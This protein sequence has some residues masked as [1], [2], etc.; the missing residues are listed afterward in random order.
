MNSPLKNTFV[1]WHALF[2]R[3][4]LDRFF[5]NRAGWVWYIVEPCI[6]VAMIAF[7]FG[8]IR[9]RV[10]VGSDVICWIIVGML[11]FF[12]FRRT[13]IQTMHAVDCN[14]AFFAFR[15]VRAFD[16]A[17][18]RGGVE[19][20]AMFLITIMLLAGC[21]LIG[22]QAVPENILLWVLL[23][24][25]MWLMGIGYGLI[26][27]VIM[28]FVPESAHIFTIIMIP[29]YMASGVIIPVASIIPHQFHKY[30]LLNPLLHGTELIRYS[31]FKV[32]HG[33]DV[34]M[35]YFFAFAFVLFFAGT[36]LIKLLES[37]LLRK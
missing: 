35:S 16:V 26:V 21:S 19:A 29:L 3:E 5:A 14:K 34:S 1:V 22:R 9:R 2:L 17:I 15:Q 33:L 30:L 36:T 32:Y 24:S 37:K 12:L 8:V 20:F 28:R 10:V 4:C 7:I 31:F 23:G 13:A 18:V 27:A 25:G 11:F 6:H